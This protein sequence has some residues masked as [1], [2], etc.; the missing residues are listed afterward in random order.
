MYNPST[1]KTG[2]KPKRARPSPKGLC[3]PPLPFLAWR[4]GIPLVFS[5]DPPLLHNCIWSA[6]LRIAVVYDIVSDDVSVI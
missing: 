1:E 6:N 3:S 4:E 2:I 5:S